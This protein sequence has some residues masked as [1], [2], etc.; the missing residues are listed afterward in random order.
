M[1][2]PLLVIRDERLGCCQSDCNRNVAVVDQGVCG[3]WEV[4][5]PGV[6]GSR[7]WKVKLV[8]VK[9]VR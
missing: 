7:L 8:E 6:D 2:S 1:A 3:P 9:V 5:A 4:E